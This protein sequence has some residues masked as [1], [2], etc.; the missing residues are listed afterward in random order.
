MHSQHSEVANLE[1]FRNFVLPCRIV[2][3]IANTI[4]TCQEEESGDFVIDISI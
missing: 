4:T 2:N 1:L 3:S